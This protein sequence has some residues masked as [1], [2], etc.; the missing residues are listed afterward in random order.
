[1]VA[2]L[3]ACR[4]GSVGL[5]AAPERET[6]ISARSLESVGADKP[7]IFLI[8]EDDG[9][10]A[11]PDLW[12]CAPT[13]RRWARHAFVHGA[14]ATVENYSFGI[15]LAIKHGRLA[16]IETTSVGIEPWVRFFIALRRFQGR[17]APWLCQAKA[18]IRFRLRRAGFSD[19]QPGGR[20]LTSDREIRLRRG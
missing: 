17:N 5:F 18:S 15:E 8:A 16:F 9:L 13:V 14:G 3:R 2:L 12:R 7:K 10:E 19:G 11:G 6:V 4:D 20:S 1:M